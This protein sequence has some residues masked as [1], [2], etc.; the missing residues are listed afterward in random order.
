VGVG[1]PE[2][3]HVA[4]TDAAPAHAPGP[5]RRPLPPAALAGL[6]DAF[7]DEVATR[8]PRLLTLLHAAPGP[9]ALRD[10]HALGSSAVVVGENDASRSARAL[11]LELG[12]DAPDPARV[13]AL[14]RELADR[15][16]GWTAR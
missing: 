7:A 5:R 15:L 14:V 16:G 10:A 8:L 4:A 2:V 11:E 3:Q 13:Q 6:R 9:D 12:A 1:V